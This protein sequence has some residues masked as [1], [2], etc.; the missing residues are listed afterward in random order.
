MLV[1]P[2]HPRA[3][4]PLRVLVVSERPFPKARLVLEPAAG[5]ERPRVLERGGPP[6]LWLAELDRPTAGRYRAALVDERGET[7]ACSA[8][9]VS[10]ARDRGPRAIPFW[11]IER[12]WNRAAENLYSA[13]IEKLFDAPLGAQVSFK[14]LHQVLRDP[15]RNLLHDHF[16]AGED[17]TD[18]K[19]A[20]VAQ[21]DCAD[22]PYFLRAYFAWKLRLPFGYR[23]C[24]RG[25]A[26]RATR[27]GP[28]RTQLDAPPETAT[29]PPGAAFSRFLRTRVSFVQSGS[30]RTAPEDDE[31]DLYPVKLSRAVLRPGTVYVDPYGH[32]LVVAR[33]VSQE[34]ERSGL[35]Y[36]VDG[37][38]DL[39]VG[40]KRFWRG[41]FMFNADI[42]SGAGGFKAFRPLVLR[43]GR[44][45][46][47]GNAELGKSSDFPAPSSEQYQLGLQGFY[48]RMDRVINP[49]PLGPRQAM[50]ERLTALYELLLERVDSVAAGEEHAKKSAFRTIAMPNGPKIFETKGAWEDF[51]TPARDLR[52]LIAIEDVLQ[53]PAR[54][55]KQPKRFA[56]AAGQAPAEARKEMEALLDRFTRDKTIQY[57][58]SDGV[59]QT[60]SMA[61][62]LARRKGLEMA[63]NPNDCV[64]LRWGGAPAEMAT[65]KRRAPEEQRQRMQAYRVWFATRTRPPLR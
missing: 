26:T 40:R 17:G 14:P 11:P 64:E 45:V 63:Y 1:S 31:S 9:Q 23:H 20:V 35:M 24:D 58:R 30:G 44:P 33:W 15:A 10:A 60:V 27:C 37:H 46:A 29:L 19:V 57:V 36:A 8:V 53:F 61:E 65:C 6:Y 55:V 32:L 39:S 22:M 48:D 43:D 54:V 5:A 50:Q 38:P 25:S 18:P 21:P 59:L 41:A 12:A 16:G 49:R 47:L 62:V 4:A 3:G 13:W 52:L 42:R 2:R 34:G 51:S 28:L 7:V 56:L